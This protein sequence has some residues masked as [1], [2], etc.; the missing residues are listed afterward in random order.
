VV[1]RRG[2]RLLPKLAYDHRHE[3]VHARSIELRSV[4]VTEHWTGV[5]GDCGPQVLRATALKGGMY[6]A[7]M[8]LRTLAFA[9]GILRGLFH[10][11]MSRVE[12]G[13]IAHDGHCRAEP[14]GR[15]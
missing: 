10:F 2:R 6:V 3:L 12:S 8:E 7:G 4:F 15:I 11:S 13:W 1:G 14:T 5:E 9:L